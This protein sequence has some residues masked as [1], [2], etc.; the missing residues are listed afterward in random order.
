MKKLAI[1]SLLVLLS[2]AL[3]A[4]LKLALRGGMST[5]E[6]NP[7]T[8]NILNDGGLRDLAI[9]L[10]NANY[11]LHGGILIQAQIGSFFIQPEVLFNS[12]SMDFRVE[13]FRNGSTYNEILRETY[14][15]LDIPIMMGFKFGSFRIQGGPVGHLYLN[16]TSDLFDIEGYSQDFDEMTYGW[17]AGIGVDIWRFLIDIKYEGNFTRLGDH[18]QIDGVD[19]DFRKTPARI[20]ASLGIS[21]FE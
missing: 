12:N 9:S 2:T 21:L 6:V 17:Q 14:Q 20:I 15:Y 1:L 5:T 10:E 18:F 19:W 8:I 3:Q 13:D 11:G 16:S 7:K 4:Q